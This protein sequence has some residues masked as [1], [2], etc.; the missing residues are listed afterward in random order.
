MDFTEGED[1][2]LSTSTLPGAVG[3][4]APLT[5]GA[6]PFIDEEG[7]MYVPAESFTALVGLQ[8]EE[9]ADQITISAQPKS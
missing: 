6:A 5:L 8:V 1:L 9:T 3:M 4:T 2:Y 7:T